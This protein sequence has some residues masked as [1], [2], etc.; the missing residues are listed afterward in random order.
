MQKNTKKTSP[1]LTNKEIKEEKNEILINKLKKLFDPLIA[2]YSKLKIVQKIYFFIFLGVITI[3][4]VLVILGWFGLNLELISLFYKSFIKPL[5]FNLKTP[6]MFFVMFGLG[7]VLP[8]FMLIPKLR[9]TNKYFKLATYL[10]LFLLIFGICFINESYKPELPQSLIWTISYKGDHPR[11]SNSPNCSIS[12]LEC[13]SVQDKKNFVID[14]EIVCTFRVN[15]NCTFEL[16]NTEI[17]K[18]LLN[19]E[20][21]LTTNYP[22]QPSMGYFKFKVE[23]NLHQIVVYPNFYNESEKLYTYFI[24]ISLYNKYSLQDYNE[25]LTKERYEKSFLLISLIS[26]SLVS[27][28]VA[29]NNLKQLLN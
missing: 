6:S 5:G 13:K 25:K 14:D 15:E 29:M 4:S 10:I 12:K 1:E 21:Q 8:L 26:L 17:T 19:N 7:F 16:K 2:K 11:F 24:F 20:S 28:I 27:V 9:K 18:F 3:Y 23:E 22:S